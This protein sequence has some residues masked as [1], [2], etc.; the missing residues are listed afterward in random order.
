MQQSADDLARSQESAGKWTISLA[1]WQ[2][3]ATIQRE[4]ATAARAAAAE[5]DLRAEQLSQKAAS[6]FERAEEGLAAARTA[7]REAAEDGVWSAA[8]E[9]A[10]EADDQAEQLSRRA[11]R[12][13]NRSEKAAA[14]ARELSQIADIRERSTTKLWEHVARKQSEAQMQATASTSSSSSSQRCP[15]PPAMSQH[16]KRPRH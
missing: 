2:H 16:A 3:F 13:F 4:K 11:V 7:A 15:D 12:A 1:S 5:A 6:A 9:A 10:T 14:A 8:F